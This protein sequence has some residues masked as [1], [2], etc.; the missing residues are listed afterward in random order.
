[1][2]SSR[3]LKVPTVKKGHLREGLMLEVILVVFSTD[4]VVILMRIM[5]LFLV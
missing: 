3:A 4:W 2:K 1:M 5:I